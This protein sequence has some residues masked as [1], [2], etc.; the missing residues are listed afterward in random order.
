MNESSGPYYTISIWN[1]LS[2][3]HQLDLESQVLT[4]QRM[5]GIKH[6]FL[7][8]HFGY[9]CNHRRL[10]FTTLR[11][12]LHTNLKV[13]ALCELLVR[14]NERIRQLIHD[15]AAEADVRDAAIDSSMLPMRTYGQSLVDDGITTHEE[16]LRVT[17]D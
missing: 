5:V 14:V 9:R 6:D 15:G 2:K 16:L 11:L 4:S 17:K 13:D 7:F 1:Y 12:Q 8:C 10:T 3:F